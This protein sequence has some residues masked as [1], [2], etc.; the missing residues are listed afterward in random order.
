MKALVEGTDYVIEN[1][2]L[3]IKEGVKAIPLESFNDNLEI[4]KVILPSTLIYIGES[5]FKSCK[6]INEINIPN[7]VRYICDQAFRKCSIKNLTLG[8]NVTYIG[9]GAFQEN[10]ITSVI[11][12]STKY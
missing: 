9:S 5:A 4:N 8:R 1:H 2:T 7:S 12:N 6:A 10:D 3:I 11:N